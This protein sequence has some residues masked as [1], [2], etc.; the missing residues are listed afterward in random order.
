MLPDVIVDDMKR[1]FKL[2]EGQYNE[3]CKTWFVT[4][5]EDLLKSNMFKLPNDSKG[6]QVE[7]PCISISQQTFIEI[8]DANIDQL[9]QNIYLHG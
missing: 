7:N 6:V 9:K 4:G 2:G 8:R 1:M 5:S 3:F